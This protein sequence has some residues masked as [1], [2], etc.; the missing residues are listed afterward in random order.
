MQKIKNEKGITLVV[1]VITV[2]VL[3]LISIPTTLKINDII[4]LNKLTKYKDDFTILSE[5]VSQVYSADMDISTIGD[6]YNGNTN[7]SGKNPNDGDTYYIINVNQLSSDLYGKVE[8]TMESLNFGKRNYG[9]LDATED[10]V[11]IIN[12]ESRTIYYVAGFENASGETIYRYPGKY[13][14][15]T[16]KS[17]D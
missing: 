12:G 8:S 5:T 2:I 4:K 7:F 16:V 6:V 1:L 14:T 11:Y 13:T 15:I 10:D 17:Y 3:G 9:D